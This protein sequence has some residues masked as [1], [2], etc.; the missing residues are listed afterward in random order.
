MQM[1]QIKSSET[2]SGLNKTGASFSILYVVSIGVDWSAA[3]QRVLILMVKRW[4]RTVDEREAA[5]AF[6]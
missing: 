3:K 6:V 4:A 5:Y 2:S 1:E